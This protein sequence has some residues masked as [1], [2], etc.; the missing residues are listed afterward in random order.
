MVAIE[1]REKKRNKIREKK[2]KKRRRNH[3]SH[4]GLEIRRKEKRRII[5][6][7]FVWLLKGKKMVRKIFVFLLLYPPKFE[8][9]EC[10]KL[11]KIVNFMS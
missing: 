11:D 4:V 5:L 6:L 7:S 8:R 3:F 9:D 2:K 10:I 1:G